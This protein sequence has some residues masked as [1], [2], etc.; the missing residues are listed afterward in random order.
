VD[1]LRAQLSKNRKYLA[2]DFQSLD[3]RESTRSSRTA[4]VEMDESDYSSAASEHSDEIQN[5][6]GIN[7]KEDIT[8]SRPHAEYVLPSNQEI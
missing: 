1:E 7:D 2:K 5:Q 6:D 3:L 4:F 8:K